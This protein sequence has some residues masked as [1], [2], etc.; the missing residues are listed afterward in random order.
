[1]KLT[2]K[3]FLGI[4]LAD[5]LSVLLNRILYLKTVAERNGNSEYATTLTHKAAKLEKK[6]RY[7]AA[8]TDAVHLAESAS[9]KKKIGRTIARLEKEIK[10]INQ[11]KDAALCTVKISEYVDEIISL[12]AKFAI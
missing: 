6:I 10:K 12:L 4:E 7:L 5:K 9:L 8:K 3:Y 11:E 1:M 2:R